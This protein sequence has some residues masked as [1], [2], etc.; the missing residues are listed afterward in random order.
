[1]AALVCFDA[2]TVDELR[3]LVFMP[4]TSTEACRLRGLA[5]AEWFRRSGLP[6]RR[7]GR[8]RW[9]LLVWFTRQERIMSVAEL[10]EALS[11]HEEG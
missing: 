6:D 5:S 10:A 9:P 8:G 3:P 2:L 11:R 7:G 1:M 4:A